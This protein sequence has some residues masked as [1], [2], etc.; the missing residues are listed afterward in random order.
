MCTRPSFLVLIALLGA[1]GGD[2]AV[3]GSGGVP[4]SAHLEVLDRPAGKLVAISGD[5]TAVIQA[6]DGQ[7][8]R[9]L[10]DDSGGRDCVDTAGERFPSIQRGN[11]SWRSADEPALFDNDLVFSDSYLVDFDR[12]SIEVFEIDTNEFWDHLV[13]GEDGRSVIAWSEGGDLVAR[14]AD[15]S[16]E[17]LG[18]GLGRSGVAL[19]TDGGIV[20]DE[21]GET[22]G[23]VL[24]VDGG[25][26][27]WVTVEPGARV[28]LAGAADSGDLALAFDLASSQQLRPTPLHLIDFSNRTA[29]ILPV[30]SATAIVSDAWFSS[31]AAAVFAVWFDAADTELMVLDLDDGSDRWRLLHTFE[32]GPGR[33]L[34]HSDS[35][36]TAVLEESIF[37]LQLDRE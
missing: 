25:A 28:V 24:R 15:G 20:V 26:V 31:D 27:E 10:L 14:R 19:S 3:E 2:L 29:E 23:A 21:I 17:E 12:R 18:R 9:V 6:L 36:V 7:L 35:A 34:G 16:H 33:L 8:C 13:V 1:C 5:G 4:T 32:D 30:P 37:R 22:S 11:G